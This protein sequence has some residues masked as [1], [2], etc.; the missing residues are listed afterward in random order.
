MALHIR[1]PQATWNTC[2]SLL[3][4]LLLLGIVLPLA[5]GGGWGRGSGGGGGGRGHHGGGGAAGVAQ[6][7]QEY[8]AVAGLLQGELGRVVGP[9]L[10]IPQGV[11]DVV[12]EGGVLLLGLARLQVDLT[13]LFRQLVPCPLHLR[14][15]VLQ[16]DNDVQLPLA[17]VLGC[18]LV[19]PP[20]SDV[21]HQ[22]HLL[23]N[24][25][26]CTSSLFTLALWV[27]QGKAPVDTVLSYL[28]LYTCSSSPPRQG[29]CWHSAQLPTALLLHFKSPK[30]S[31]DT[32]LSYLQ[33][34][35]SSPPKQGTCWHSAQ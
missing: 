35:T 9:P 23:T 7:H 10:L 15:G 16:G 33:L 1:P 27:P 17:A 2:W 3:A 5:A 28:Q 26:A 11:E 12:I 13:A 32:V 18:H 19:L 8:V 4:L 31:V 24:N 21:S 20:A 34:Y 25:A 6:A 29:I 30:A 22:R 14:H